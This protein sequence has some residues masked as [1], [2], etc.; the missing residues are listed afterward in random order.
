MSI[1]QALEDE[2]NGAASITALI[3]DDQIFPVVLPKSKA[4]PAIVYQVA[5]GGEHAGHMEGK[6]GLARTNV[7][8]RVYGSTYLE[9]ITI[10]EAVR[11]LLDRFHGVMGTTQTANV[12]SISMTGPYDTFEPASQDEHESVHG[13]VLS[14]S[15]WHTESTS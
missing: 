10:A 3:G 15:I 14:L 5:P 13:K 8:L 6:S 11:L 4:V 9:T 2:L 1:E 12:R 7:D